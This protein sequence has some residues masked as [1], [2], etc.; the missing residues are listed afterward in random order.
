M[1]RVKLSHKGAGFYSPVLF[2]REWNFH[3]RLDQW[4]LMRDEKPGEILRSSG[5]LRIF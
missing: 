1:Y 2:L 4:N 5:S 3:H